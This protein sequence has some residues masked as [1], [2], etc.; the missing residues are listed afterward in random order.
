M[1]QFE[2]DVLIRYLQ[3]RTTEEEMEAIEVAM[4][5]D[6]NL[7]DD[8]LALEVLLNGMASES[9]G[10]QP[11]QQLSTIESRIIDFFSSAVVGVAATATSLLLAF[12]LITDEPSS[13]F[14]VSQE[15]NVA[16]RKGTESPHQL[17]LPSDGMILLSI[18]TPELN[19]K[20]AVKIV[21]GSE[22]KL[23][24]H[25]QVLNGFVLLLVDSKALSEDAYEISLSDQLGQTLVY[26]IE[27]IH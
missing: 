14:P 10:S 20:V 17:T 23:F 9:I 24:S 6:Q 13:I 5:E 19:G 21:T 11:E 3:K 18:H 7:V 4:L 1:T 27:L 16:T 2:D 8:I 25:S 12:L 15:W 22:T 26:P